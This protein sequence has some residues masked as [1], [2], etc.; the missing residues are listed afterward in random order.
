MW[1]KIKNIWYDLKFG[2]KNLI[3]WFPKIWKLRDFDYGYGVDLFI[4]YLKVLRKGMNKYQ[5]YIGYENDIRRIDTFLK[6]YDFYIELEYFKEYEEKLRKEGIPSISYNTY[7]TSEQEE[8]K[9]ELFKEC[10]D[11]EKRLKKILWKYLEY[12][13]EYWWD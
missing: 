11:K 13:L 2:I 8:R 12:N 9:S 5:S 3:F 7:L 6:L 10:L 1:K 4:S